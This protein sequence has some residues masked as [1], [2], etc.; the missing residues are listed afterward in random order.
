MISICLPTRG[1][2]EPFK[3]MCLSAL[4]TADNP[5]DI[6]FVSYHDIDD[7]SV[8]EYFGNHKE[9]LGDRIVQSAMFNECQKIATG[10]IYMFMVDDMVFETYGWDTAVTEVFKKSDDKILFVYPNDGIYRHIKAGFG[11]VGFIHKN[12][13][14]TVGYFLPP[15]F[16]A[17]YAD[18]WINALAGRINRKVYLPQIQLKHLVVVDDETHKDYQEKIT[19]SKE[20]YYSREKHNERE[21]DA[22]LL[23]GF[24]DKNQKKESSKNNI[25]QAVHILADTNSVMYNHQNMKNAELENIAKSVRKELFTFKTRAGFGHPAST[26]STVDIVVSMYHDDTTAFD[27]KKDILIFS[28]AHGSPALYPILA[29][30]GFFPKEELDKYCTPEGILRVHSDGSIP[31]CHFVG[32]SLG[33]GIGYAA[34]LA[35]GKRDT[36][37]Y[38]ILGDGELYEGSVWEALMFIAH[39]KLQNVTLIIDRN[40]L[41]TLGDTEKLLALEPLADKFKAFGFDTQSIDGHNFDALRGALNKTSDIP[42]AIIA[43]T[44]KGKG[45]SYM[46]GVWMYHVI[47]PKDDEATRGLKELS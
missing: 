3:Q 39:N 42:R 38:V 44:V 23:Q 6:E 19:H 40:K 2:P 37:V 31:G 13:I 46:E 18:N 12:W 41:T 8:Y 4:K 15:Y 7:T 17:W 11:A 5:N 27:H 9:V 33:N 36:N 20:I 21:R 22:M 35:M 47:V 45:V 10:P 29:N 1:R 43:N 30:L 16:A 26:L 25:S 34:G 28:K 24:I 32:G 14:D